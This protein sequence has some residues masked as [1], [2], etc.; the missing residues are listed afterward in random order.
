MPQIPTMANLL[1]TF[2]GSGNEAAAVAVLVGGQV[3][4]HF[5]DEKFSAYKNTCAIRVS[6][7][8]NY[9]GDPVP[10]GGGGLSN[11]YM[12]NKKI[13]TDKGGDGNYYIYSVY[14]LCAYLTGRYGH[15][16]R[17]KN[18]LTQSELAAKNVKGIIV[19]AFVHADIWNGTTCAYHNE[20]FGQAKVQEILIYPA[21]GE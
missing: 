18:T 11:P 8:L 20:E 3:K 5:E 9:G 17:F 10:K 15:P 16:K 13:R 21:S 4:E 14:D 19:F 6:R 12:D 1:K 7:A 2:P